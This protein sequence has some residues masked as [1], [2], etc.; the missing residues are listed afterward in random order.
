MIYFQ[1][2]MIKQKAKLEKSSKFFQYHQKKFMATCVQLWSKYT[3][4]KRSKRSLK[5]KLK[6]YVDKSLKKK[7]FYTLKLNKVLKRLKVV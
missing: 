3:Q 2:L 1:L 4:K 7:A 6:K 5:I